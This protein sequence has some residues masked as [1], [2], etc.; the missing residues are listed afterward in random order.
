MILREQGTQLNNNSFQTK[1]QNNTGQNQP[2]TKTNTTT[3]LEHSQTLGH[4]QLVKF[5]ESSFLQKK[6]KIQ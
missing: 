3:T 2:I 5:K 6:L 1:S 4:L